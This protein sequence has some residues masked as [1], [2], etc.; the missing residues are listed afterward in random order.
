MSSDALEGSKEALGMTGATWEVIALNFL[1]SASRAA[2]RALSA[3]SSS[4]CL[5][6]GV[7]GGLDFSPAIGEGV[8]DGIG[9][10]ESLWEELEGLSVDLLN[11]VGMSC[12]LFGVFNLE[13]EAEKIKKS[14]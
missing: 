8:R 3:V 6:S 7:L 10:G 5:S 4:S 2:M 13:N 1:T 11:I 14:C 12:C 9:D